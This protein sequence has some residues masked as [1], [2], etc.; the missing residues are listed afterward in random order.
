MDYYPFDLDTPVMQNLCKL[1]DFNSLTEHQI[2]I[3][4]LIVNEHLSQRQIIE[5]WKEFYGEKLI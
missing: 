4:N 3:L 1:I 2:F 5:K